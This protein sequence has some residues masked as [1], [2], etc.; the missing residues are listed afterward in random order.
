[1]S[2]GGYSFE[3]ASAQQANDTFSNVG[4]VTFSKGI[5]SKW[6]IGAAAAVAVV[7][8]LAMIKRKG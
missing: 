6:F 4:A 2:G 1:M 5:D 8:V 7:I 3:Q